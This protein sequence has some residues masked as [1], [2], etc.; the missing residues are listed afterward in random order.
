MTKWS[1]RAEPFERDLFFHWRH[2]QARREVGGDAAMSGTGKSWNRG[3]GIGT[4]TLFSSLL[5]VIFHELL[6]ILLQDIVNFIHQL[7]EVFFYLLAF[8]HDLRIGCDRLVF[9]I[10]LLFLL[11]LFLLFRHERSPHVAIMVSNSST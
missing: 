2:I 4:P 1:C 10:G 5:D 11:F 8:F 9:L 6:R 3:H 7:I